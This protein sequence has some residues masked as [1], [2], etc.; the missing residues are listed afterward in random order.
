MQHISFL[1]TIDVY[2]SNSLPPLHEY[3]MSFQVFY[4][5]IQLFYIIPLI[6][7]YDVGRLF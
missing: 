3:D 5:N 7:E 6:L 1:R 2:T 4:K